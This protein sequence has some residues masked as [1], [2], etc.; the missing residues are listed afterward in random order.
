MF[1]MLHDNYFKACEKSPFYLSFVLNR[2]DQLIQTSTAVRSTVTS[3]VLSLLSDLSVAAEYV[4]QAWLC[5]H[6][7]ELFCM[8]KSIA[9]HL[10]FM[11]KRLAWLCILNLRL[12]LLRN[13]HPLRPF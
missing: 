6:A 3:R 4:R 9:N 11:P 8:T 5:S 7:P 13:K 10:K 2:T 1:G 12:V